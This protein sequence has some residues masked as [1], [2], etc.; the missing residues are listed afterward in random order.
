MIFVSELAQSLSSHIH[1]IDCVVFPSPM[2]GKSKQPKSR[3]GTTI[4][5]TSWKL[6]EEDVTTYQ[7]RL[8][9]Y[10]KKMLQ[11]IRNFLEVTERRCY[12]VSGTSWKLLEDD[13]N[14][15]KFR[16]QISDNMDK[17][18]RTSRK[19]L[20]HGESQKGKNERWRRPTR[21]GE[22]QKREDEGAQTR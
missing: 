22:N 14:R 5:G 9:S 21:D 12:N 18:K 2:G 16:N 15:R 20:Q 13:V 19:T 11:R 7:E 3:I 10:W 8:G 6:L 4:S 17:W 1:Q